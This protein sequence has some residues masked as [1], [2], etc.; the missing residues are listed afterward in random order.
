VST[1][2]R[3][4][5]AILWLAAAA[6]AADLELAYSALELPGAPA[7]IIPVQMDD[8]E[9]LELAVIVVYTA[10]DELALEETSEIDEIDGLVAMLTIVPALLENRELWLFDRDGEGRWRAAAEPLELASDVLSI[11]ATRHPAVPLLALTDGGADVIRTH[12][13]ESGRF[14]RERLVAART[15]IAGSGAFLPRLR[16]SHDLDGDS[17]P[18]LL[19]PT[20]EGWQ[21]HRGVEAGFEGEPERTLAL[22][23]FED[24]ETPW[25]HD[26][27]LPEV[28]DVDGDGHA[29]V[30][31]RHP[32]QGWGTFFVY[33][34]DRGRGFDPVIGPLG[35]P[36]GAVGRDD[37]PAIVFF[38]DIDGDGRAEYVS[39]ETV[40]LEDDAGMRREMAHA[41]RTPHRYRILDATA[42][43]APAA[44]PRLEFETVG[45]SF[46][47][48]SDVRLPGGLWDL[49]GDGRRD[50]VTLTLDFSMLQAL[51]V[52]VAQSLSIGLEF[53]VLCQNDDGG[54]APV[55]GLDLSGKFRLDLKNFR[56]GQLSL[57]GGDF[58]GDGRRDFVQIGSGKDVSIHRGAPG[59]RFPRAPDFEIRLVDEPRDL[60]L[61]DVADLDGDGLS[62]LSVVQ[63]QRDKGS[64]TAPVRV[65][66]YLSGGGS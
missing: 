17:W 36:P 44:E 11:E 57:F 24:T 45:Y 29:D 56:Q 18:D 53:Q 65:D 6:R 13:E 31:V 7:Q 27:P 26:L 41:K 50:L 63:P 14:E 5:A 46:P 37:G 66:L 48:A 34:N 59:C 2:V 23:A 8:D 61:V 1:I 10:W 12:R 4:A 51:R 20:A 16:W 19:L 32:L 49:D 42:T 60:A 40:E 47:D 35:D 22:P 54:F 15:A 43:L 39:Q 58:D 3:A 33:R 64:E 21:L 30:L 38:D 55:P 62:D 25:R 28:R 9:S 52:V